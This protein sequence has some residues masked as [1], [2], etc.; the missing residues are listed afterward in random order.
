LIFTKHG[1]YDGRTIIINNKGKIFNIIGGE[2][3]VDVESNLLFTIYECDISGYAVFDLK[4]DLLL[5]AKD[6]IIERPISIQ[7][8]ENK[9]FMIC[10]NDE[11]E[12]E[13]FWEFDLE[14][15]KIKKSAIDK[16]T[17]GTNNEL[18]RLLTNEVNCVCEE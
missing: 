12:E 9:Y 10:K 7:K 18:Q 8:T 13:S 5:W 6:D 14:M 3:Y 4:S 16:K 17:I 11:T 1:D 2:N 15:K